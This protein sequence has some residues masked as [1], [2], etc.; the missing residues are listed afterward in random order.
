M[1]TFTGR[2]FVISN[3]KNWRMNTGLYFEVINFRKMSILTNR[4][5][6]NL[7]SHQIYNKHISFKRHYILTNEC[8][9]NMRIHPNTLFC[10]PDTLYIRIYFVS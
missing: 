9:K 7:F 3:L 5:F 2:H 8:L 10:P 4:H 1:P 6:A